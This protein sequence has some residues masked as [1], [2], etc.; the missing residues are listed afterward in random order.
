MDCRF[1]TDMAEIA[2]D[3]NYLMV[4]KDRQTVFFDGAVQGKV[5]LADVASIVGT[6][7]SVVVRLAA[8]EEHAC[9]FPSASED[10]I[11]SVAA[12][13]NECVVSWR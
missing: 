11:E 13:L 1:E 3:G 5:P 8:G 7:G 10:E 4:C 6:H 2:G 12:R 9:P